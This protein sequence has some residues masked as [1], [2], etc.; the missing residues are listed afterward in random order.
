MPN[1]GVN[2][3]IAGE[4][5]SLTKEVNKDNIN[6]KTTENMENGSSEASGN[7]IEESSDDCILQFTN[8]S[9]EGISENVGGEASSLT[10]EV[11]KDNI[12]SK[13]TENIEN[14]SK[15]LKDDSIIQSVPENPSGLPSLDDV[16]VLDGTGEA[17]GSG[18]EESSDDC[19]LQFTNKPNEGV[20]ENIGGEVLSLTQ[21]V[22]KDNINSKT[23][24]TIENAS[25][26]LKDES[27]IQSVPENPSDLPSIDDVIVLDATGE[28]SESVIED[29]SYEVA[30]PEGVCL[31]I[32]GDETNITVK[33]AFESQAPVD[34][35]P[36]YETDFSG[37]LNDI[38]YSMITGKRINDARPKK[39]CFNC[40]ADHNLSECPDP[41]DHGKIS[42]NRRKHMTTRG[43][44][45]RYHEDSENKFGHF[46]PG[47]LSEG[48]RHALGL[49][50]HQLPLYIYRMRVLGYPPGWLLDAEVH[51][52]D[53]KMYD[54]SGESVSHPDTEEGEES[55]TVKYKPE[56][57]VSYP[58]FNDSVPRGV[59]DEWQQYNFPP[60]QPIHQR[61]EFLRYMNMNKAEAYKKKKLKGSELRSK[62]LNDSIASGA[63]MEVDES[64]IAR[65]T[66][67]EF[68]PPLPLEPLPPPPPLDVPPLPPLPKKVIDIEEGEISE[69]SQASLGDLEVKR[70]KILKELEDTAVQ[71]ADGDVEKSQKI[72]NSKDVHAV[73]VEQVGEISEDSRLSS[74]SVNE[75]SQSENSSNDLSENDSKQTYHHR[76]NS[77]SFK[78][79]VI[80][81]ES[82]TPY[83]T[84]PSADKWTVDVSDHIVFENLPDAL[85][86]WEKMKG[87]MSI[88]K[89]RMSDLHA[90]DDE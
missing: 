30:M 36:S 22:T 83:K 48:L 15:L 65:S 46:Q 13:T 85:G 1:E 59:K 5:S 29:S 66:E 80:I 87:I 19:I 71:S 28:A 84:L 26:L 81:P 76:S 70:L 12:C 60:M 78:L 64:G 50:P 18:I 9:N 75:L 89:K 44:N 16:I 77:K 10:E 56:S 74:H 53:V 31:D 61:S 37:V 8:I 21:G 79:G 72:K 34:I 11:T 7:K 58:G 51:Q 14:G 17:S 82:C 90:D 55:T 23:T 40:L 49:K 6:S 52:A 69:D 67:I 54:A 73:N 63:E 25:K 4:A 57:L 47:K 88:V 68:N 45:V 20:N 24:E 38:E 2:E 39:R 3:N 86:T 43:S 35:T 41:L 33:T 27:I 32:D 42:A 62:S